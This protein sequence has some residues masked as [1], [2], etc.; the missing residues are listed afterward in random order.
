MNQDDSSFFNRSLARDGTDMPDSRLTES[1]RLARLSE[2]KISAHRY[3]DILREKN[4]QS[5]AQ[6]Y[7]HRKTRAYQGFVLFVA[8]L[9]YFVLSITQISETD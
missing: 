1:V 6:K 5:L 7:D 9:K 8:S 4:E 3:K 2:E